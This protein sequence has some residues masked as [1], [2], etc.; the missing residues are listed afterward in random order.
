MTIVTLRKMIFLTEDAVVSRESLAMTLW[1]V[2]EIGLQALWFFPLCPRECCQ[3]NL[4]TE[5]PAKSAQ[6][7]PL[8]LFWILPSG[9]FQSWLKETVPQLGEAA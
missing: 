6:V 2:F 4:F 1:Y 7:L 3:H 9:F 8:F 5:Q